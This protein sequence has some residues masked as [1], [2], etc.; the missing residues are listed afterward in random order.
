MIDICLRFEASPSPLKFLLIS[1][2]FICKV[3]PGK[4]ALLTWQRK[5]NSKGN[6]PVQFNLSLKEVLHMVSLEDIFA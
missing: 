6:D 4:P 5:L 3:D 2:F 1:D